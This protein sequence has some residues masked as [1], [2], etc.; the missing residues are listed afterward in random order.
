ML[1]SYRFFFQYLHIIRLEALVVTTK[2]EVS[3]AAAVLVAGWEVV[4]VVIMS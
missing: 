2:C 3:R 1:Y 4:V